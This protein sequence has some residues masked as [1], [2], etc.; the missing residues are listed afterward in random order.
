MTKNKFPSE[1]VVRIFQ[2]AE[3]L[4]KTVTQICRDKGITKLTF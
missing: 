3:A 4:E 2:E 1:Q